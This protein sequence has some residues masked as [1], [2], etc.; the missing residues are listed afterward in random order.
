MQG[1]HLGGLSEAI[2]KSN[3]HFAANTRGLKDMPVIGKAPLI[4]NYNTRAELGEK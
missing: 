2:A 4:V 3:H 1:I